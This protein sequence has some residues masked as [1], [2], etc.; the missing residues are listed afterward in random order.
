MQRDWLKGIVPRPM[1]GLLHTRLSNDDLVRALGIMEQSGWEEMTRYIEAVIP[2]WKLLPKTLAAKYG[3]GDFLAKVGQFC[4]EI[5]L[6]VCPVS[7]SAPASVELSPLLQ[8]DDQ[9][10]VRITDELPP[11]GYV[12]VDVPSGPN[13]RH[14]AAFVYRTA[15]ITV[16]SCE[17]SE[18]Y[19]FHLTDWALNSVGRRWFLEEVYEWIYST[20][21]RLSVAIR[22]PMTD[23]RG[24]SVL[25]ERRRIAYG[26]EDMDATNS[27]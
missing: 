23:F 11:E 26:Y 13:T 22:D 12:I 25:H 9:T 21:T 7:D 1:N 16:L 24:D 2:G 5:C 14:F 15:A 20:A 8:T 4:E 18:T 17:E 10:S 19:Y 27:W 3:A 6:L